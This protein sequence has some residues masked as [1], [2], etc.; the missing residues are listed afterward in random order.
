MEINNSTRKCIKYNASIFLIGL[1]HDIY[2]KP[3]PPKKNLSPLS[4]S[5]IFAVH[6]TESPSFQSTL[7]KLSIHYPPLSKVS[8]AVLQLQMFSE[9]MTSK[10][11]ASFSYRIYLIFNVTSHLRTPDCLP[12]LNYQ[13]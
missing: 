13:I 2:E 6:H 11:Y 12:L 4:F 8:Q 5:Q 9:S 3:F 10:I 1:P 7:L